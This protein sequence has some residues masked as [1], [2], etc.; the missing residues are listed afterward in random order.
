[1]NLNKHVLAFFL[2]AGL[3][4]LGATARADIPP[5][6]SCQSPGAACTNAGASFNQAG[7]CVADTC[8]KATPTG[9]VQ[10]ACMVCRV[11]GEGDA[12]SPVPADGGSSDATDAGGS[13]GTSGSG[14]TTG[15]G[16]VSGSGGTSGG[17]GALPPPKSG[18]DGCDLGGGAPVD[19]RGAAAIALMAAA[20][21]RRRWRR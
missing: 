9:S 10:Y 1:M 7:H 8:T 14:G 21:L 11:A 13:G 19:G 17:G 16:G 12:G 15:S 18:G 4:F 5:P 2:A 20:W 3:S 6:D